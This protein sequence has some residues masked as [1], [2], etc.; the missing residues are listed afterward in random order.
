MEL[1]DLEF[2]GPTFNWRGHRNSHLVEIRLD[3]ALVNKE[4]LLLWPNTGVFHATVLGL[5]Q[6]PLIVQGEPRSDKCKRLFRF[7]AY[8]SNEE[9]CKD[10]VRRCWEMVCLGDSVTRW[11]KR[12]NDCRSKLLTWSRKKFKFQAHQIEE[13]LD[14][15]GKLQE[16]W[17]NNLKQIEDLSMEIDAL[18]RHEECYWQ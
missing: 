10:I 3:C 15:L 12:V 18:S 17:G 1:I 9:E 8:W 5:D 4:W 16:E 11:H 14:H 2:N 7:E 6:N 13:K